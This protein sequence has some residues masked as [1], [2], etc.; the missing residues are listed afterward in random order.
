MTRTSPK[1]RV[2]AAGAMIVTM[3]ICSVV[4]PG[5]RHPV[6]VPEGELVAVSLRA[7]QNKL[8]T[9]QQAG[10]CSKELLQ[11]GSLRTVMGF[12]ADENNRD[13][14]LFGLGNPAVPPLSVEDLAVA[15]RNAWNKYAYLDGG[16][17]RAPGCSI[18]PDPSVTREL[19]AI[20]Q[21]MDNASSEGPIEAAIGDW[22]EVCRRPQTVRVLGIPFDTHFAE[23]M[24][25]ADYDL[26]TLAD[27]SAALDVPGFTSLM[28]RMAGERQ[29]ALTGR[30]DVA[31]QRSSL[32][33]F[34]FCPGDNIYE[35]NQGVVLI[36]QCPVKLLTER[37]H[38][39]AGGRLSGTSSTDDQAQDFTEVFSALFERISEQRPVYRQLE[40]LFRL[41][42]IADALNSRYSDGKVD[43]RYLLDEFPVSQTA[44]A[45][46]LPGR[47][48]V[49][50][51]E[52]RE[53]S[54]SG[55]TTYRL[56]IPS[57]GGV[58]LG[59]RN[60]P[61]QFLPDT[62]GRLLSLGKGILSSKG[63]RESP[64]WVYKASFVS[65]LS[66][67]LRNQDV[68][69]GNSDFNVL[70]VV[71]TRTGYDVYD[72]THRKVYG[73][74]DIS[75]LLRAV[76]SQFGQDP[77]KTVYLDLKGFSQDKEQAFA[78]SCRIRQ[79]RDN[80]DTWL[81]TLA[82]R[83]DG[84]REPM[85]AFFSRGV[86]LEAEPDRPERV[87]DGPQAGW[88]RASLRFLVQTAGKIQKI[89]IEVFAKTADLAQE[90]VDNVKSLLSVPKYRAKSTAAIANQVRRQL[91]K[92]Y[93]L[94]DKDLIIHFRDQFG[95][96]HI[97]V[98]RSGEV[99]EL[100]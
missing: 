95:S 37:M 15:L 31:L 40:N 29:K 33:R 39:D 70:T 56:W 36:E 43:L 92:K 21:R 55:Y 12:V 73:G 46:N 59:M 54:Q 62:S 81:R 5:C 3:T 24:V 86:T 50:K 61:K 4:T 53:D 48:A 72:A 71:D 9:C 34:W 49:K 79:E 25:G 80:V 74:N 100:G 11:M 18:D 78:S 38:S 7:L 87:R 51:I 91:K 68:N 13:V 94:T 42:A 90:F 30:A 64:Y 26:K 27:G 89:G 77:D 6:A 22:Q 69:R 10:N 23:V 14:I 35:E 52:H 88:Y 97:A 41:A 28:D 99:E 16:A 17:Y 96:T 19:D 45:H 65:D 58:D 57:C 32:N 47:E 60:A 20:G 83:P 84:S 93:N 67:D 76:H 2:A 66:N 82:R 75:E 8:K 63:S 98:I 44:V 1:V 85:D